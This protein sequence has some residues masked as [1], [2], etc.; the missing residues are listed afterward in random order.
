VLPILQTLSTNICF[1]PVR[2][3]SLRQRNSTALEIQREG[4]FLSRAQ[5]EEDSP[6]GGLE[7]DFQSLAPSR[8]APR[9]KSRTRDHRNRTA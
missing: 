1:R 4:R 9:F 8:L 3:R 2:F 5:D 7:R 6:E